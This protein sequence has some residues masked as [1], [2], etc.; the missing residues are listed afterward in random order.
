MAYIVMAYVVMAYVVMAYIVMAYIVMAYIVMAYIVMAY[1]VMAY[2]VMAFAERGLD[3]LIWNV[4]TCMNAHAR[5]IVRAVRVHIYA[6]LP[7]R[8]RGT[9]QNLAIT[10][11]P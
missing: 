10:N 1:I 9:S 8:D 11:M 5:A 7:K 3:P 4:R 6:N 2:I